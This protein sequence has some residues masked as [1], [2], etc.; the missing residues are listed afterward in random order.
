M[1]SLVIVDDEDEQ[2]NGLARYFP[3]ATYGFAVAGAFGDCQSA[4]AFCTS[5]RVDVLLCDIRLPFKSG[6]DLIDALYRKDDPPLFCIMS[7]YNSFDYAKQA[8]QYG[9][10]DFLVKPS[11]FEEIGS[12][13]TRLRKKLDD[14]APHAPSSGEAG[15]NTLIGKALILMR[16]KTASCTLQS[17]ADQLD[18]STSYLSRL[19]RETTGRTFQATLI[20]LRME[21]AKAMLHSD[22]PY[23][24]REIAQAVGYQDPQNFCRTFKSCTGMTPQ[25]WKRRGGLTPAPSGR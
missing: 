14:R 16:E 15:T 13:F 8:M 7:A 3:W 9:V 23:T 2:R 21:T 17:V 22:L 1:Y 5:R 24:N 20:E 19:F 18:L 11:S 12:V 4:E 10:Q 6:F 25:E